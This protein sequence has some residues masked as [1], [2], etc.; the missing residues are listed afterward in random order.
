MILKK[1]ILLIF[2]FK[3]LFMTG[4]LFAYENKIILKV[5]NEI[6]TNYDIEKEYRYL[7][8]LNKNIANLDKKKV[9]EVSKNSL[10]KEKIKK[11]EILR[12]INEIKLDDKYINQ[13]IKNIYLRIGI[14]NL[15]EF[16]KY[17]RINKVD[18]DEVVNKISIEALWNDLIYVKYNK[19][20]N[21]NE[22]ELRDQ[23]VKINNKK[24]KI[25]DLSEI[26]FEVIETN[27]F[28]E[29]KKAIY[30]NISEI[31]FENTAQQ[32]S[33]SDSSKIGGKIGLIEEN[34][35]SKKIKNELKNMKIGQIS[36]PIAM[37]GGFLILKINKIEKTKNDFDMELEFNKILKFRKNEQLNQFSNIYFSKIKKNIQINEL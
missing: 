36:R 9:F 31:G 19:K 37:P 20:I 8:T 16:Q 27:D 14:A 7:S 29:I 15:E 33:I 32:F 1:K 3:F 4:C 5:D 35:L 28:E 24:I 11:I 13:I 30:D 6:I 12:N 17:L 26:F 18:Y 23:L 25:F 34:K 21:I 22:K 2:L 10:I